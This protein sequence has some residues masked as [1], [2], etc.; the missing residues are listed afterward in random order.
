MLVRWIYISE[1]RIPT[2]NADKAVRDIV[3]FS[4]HRNRSLKIT[5]AL[6]FT[7]LH[8]AQYI[9]GTPASAEA[10]KISIMRDQR[11]GEIRTIA[12]EPFSHRHFLDWS[13]AYAGP[14]RFVANTIEG[15][16]SKVIQRGHHNTDRLVKLMT[17]FTI[18]G[19]S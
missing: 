12:D 16:L 10:L 17:E 9:E 3:N 6:L 5:G 4:I 13:L 15:A 8:F 18:Q 19:R 2:G 7:G 1:S 11:H 14:S